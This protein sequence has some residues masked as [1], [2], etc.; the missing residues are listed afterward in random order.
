MSGS[1]ALFLDRDGVINVDK[2]Y[3]HQPEECEFVPG[4]ITLIRRANSDGL[5]VLIVTN[6]AGIARG[7][8]SEAHFHQFTEWMLERLHEQGAHV[9]RVYFCP[10]HPTAGLGD[11]LQDCE[12]RKPRPGMFRRAMDEFDIDMVRSV[13]VGDTLNDMKAAAEAGIHRRYLFLPDGYPTVHGTAKAEAADILK[14]SDLAC[15]QW[16]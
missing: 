16:N 7:Y 14:I 10:H 8:Y 12:C 1:R 13:M 4:I 15:V 6:Q 11:Y 9:D 2:G 3:V 5:R